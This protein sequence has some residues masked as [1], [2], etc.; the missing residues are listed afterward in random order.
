MNPYYFRQDNG[1]FFLIPAD[2]IN[3]FDELVKEIENTEFGAD[4]MDELCESFDVDFLQYKKEGDM[5]DIKLYL[6]E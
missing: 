1:E 4:K 6:E 5:F 3:E 2:Q